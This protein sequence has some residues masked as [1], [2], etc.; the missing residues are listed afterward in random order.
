M[1]L[2]YIKCLIYVNLLL[3]MSCDLNE[4]ICLIKI[5]YYVFLDI[6]LVY[7]KNY[8]GWLILLFE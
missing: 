1:L 2:I 3:V 4:E 7:C 8:Y 5:K 6:I